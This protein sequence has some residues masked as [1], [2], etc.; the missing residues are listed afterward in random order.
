MVGPTQALLQRLLLVFP[1]CGLGLEMLLVMVTFL[2]GGF[3]HK[4]V[5]FLLAQAL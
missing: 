3:K 2:L 1:R 4:G 5:R